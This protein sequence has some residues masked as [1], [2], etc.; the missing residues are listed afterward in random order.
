MGAVK[1]QEF[2][3]A[4][5]HLDKLFRALAASALQDIRQ[6]LEQHSVALRRRIANLDESLGKLTAVAEWAKG[7]KSVLVV[8]GKIV[9][10]V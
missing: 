10:L 2:V 9:D 8:P 5:L 1:R 6:E 4:R 3:S 7:V